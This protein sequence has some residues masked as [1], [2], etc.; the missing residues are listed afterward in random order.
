MSFHPLRTGLHKFSSIN[1]SY[2]TTLKPFNGKLCLVIGL[3]PLVIRN[4]FDIPTPHLSYLIHQQECYLVALKP[5]LILGF[6]WESG[7]DNW[8]SE[9]PVTLLRL[10]SAYFL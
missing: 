5:F 2:I 3:R 1:K 6:V 9:I 10:S 7:Q 4:T 8:L